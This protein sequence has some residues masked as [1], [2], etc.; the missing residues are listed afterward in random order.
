MA[1]GFE[2]TIESRSARQWTSHSKGK[3][4]CMI[5]QGELVETF[6][7]NPPFTRDHRPDERIRANQSTAETG[8]FERPRHVDAVHK[9]MLKVE[10]CKSPAVGFR[11]RIQTPTFNLQPSAYNRYRAVLGSS[12][13]STDV[14][15]SFRDAEADI[16][17]PSFS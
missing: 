10:G 3:R 8:Q 1:T 16:S 11:Q 14:L 7:Y 17:S 6:S 5:D 4:F 15:S 13:P 12:Y 9:T 2:I